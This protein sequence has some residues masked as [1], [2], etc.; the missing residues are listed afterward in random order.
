MVR[1]F[2]QIAGV[3][4]VSFAILVAYTAI[5]AN[6]PCG[7]RDLGTRAHTE[8]TERSLLSSSPLDRFNS[9]VYEEYTITVWTSPT[10][11]P[12][13]N[14]IR[15]ELPSL[16]RAGFMVYIF[17]S[18]IITPPSYVKAFPTVTLSHGDDLISVGNYWKAKDI[19]KVV[20][21]L[22]GLKR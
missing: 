5:P 21:T 2:I 15:E 13:K 22:I 20:Y 16:L 10:C 18:E 7:E 11:G 19:K 17:D 9:G 3:F 1:R 14:Y 4:Y 12:C 8:E 6:L